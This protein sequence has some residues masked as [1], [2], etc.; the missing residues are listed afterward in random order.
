[1]Q[2]DEI[3]KTIKDFQAALNDSSFISQSDG[4]SFHVSASAG[5]CNS[6]V[7]LEDILEYLN[8][9]D[10]ALYHSKKLLSPGQ[11]TISD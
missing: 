4:S 6:A 1:M 7:P 8:K 5:I 11:L 2:T 9:A 10:A 3:V